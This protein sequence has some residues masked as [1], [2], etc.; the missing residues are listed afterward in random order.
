MIVID[1]DRTPTARGLH[2]NAHA[3]ARYATLCQEASIVPIVEPEVLID[4]A[5]SIERCAEV[6]EAAQHALFD[7][8]WKERVALEGILLKPSMVDR[9]QELPRARPP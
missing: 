2:A 9:R 4:G 8:L 1:G 7:A 5:H 3:L 6:T